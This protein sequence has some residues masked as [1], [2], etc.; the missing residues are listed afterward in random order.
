M[1]KF[2]NITLNTIVIII[3]F[4]QFIILTK[5]SYKYNF[6]YDYGNKLK[7][8]CTKENVEYETNRYQLNN[9]I[10]NIEI[11]NYNHHIILILSIIF[12][13]TISIIFTFIFYN[14]FCNMNKNF[15][16]YS[17]KSKIY[18]LFIILITFCILINP[19]L[20]ILFKLFNLKYYN[21]ISLFNHNINK[22]NLYIISSIFI[23]LI[24]FK[25]IIIY[26]DYNIPEFI[27]EKQNKNTRYI[28]L[29]YFIFYLF[30]YIGTLYYITNIILLY[31]YK[32]KEFTVDKNEF[33]DNKSIIGQYINKLFGLS[34]HDK[35]IE[36]IEYI[37]KVD[38]EIN[39]KPDTKN[40][41]LPKNLNNFN[42]IPIED[43]ENIQK[44]IKYILDNFQEINTANIDTKQIINKCIKDYMIIKY[45]SN[46]P[47]GDKETETNL[48]E[49]IIENDEINSL[50][51]ENKKIIA[52][53][54]TQKISKSIQMLDIKI[55]KNNDI[56]DESEIIEN[57]ELYELYTSD[58]ISIFR[59]NV[60]GLLFIIGI[61]LLSIFIVNFGISFYNQKFCSR[62]KNNIIIPLLSLYILI[63][64]LI[65]NDSFNKIINN[66]IIN[67]PKF[68]YKNNI[69]NIN[70]N[71]NKILENELYIYE[72]TNN[73]LCKNA[74]NSFVSVI[75]NILFHK[76]II[77]NN[78][79]TNII[80]FPIELTIYDNECSNNK[81]DID[82]NLET[83]LDGIFY[84]ITDCSIIY[85]N[86]IKYIIQNTTIYDYNSLELMNLLKDI[87]S[88]PFN[89]SIE[90]TILY[91]IINKNIK[92]ENIKIMITKIKQKLKNLLK[93]TLYN[94]IVLKKSYDNFDITEKNNI[95][96]LSDN[97]YNNYIN[98]E[99][100]NS[101]INKYNYIIDNIIDEYINM[102]LINHYLLSKLVNT[103]SLNEIF[104][105]IDKNEIDY[106]LKK[107]MTEYI[108]NFIELYKTYLNKLNLIFKNKYNL[109][110]K[111]NNISLYLINIYNNINK[112]NPY[113]DDIIYPYSK[114]ENQIDNMSVMVRFNKNL[115]NIINDYDKLR[116]ICNDTI[117]YNNN[118]CNIYNTNY[119]KK[120]LS[121]KIEN[122]VRVNILNIDK[123]FGIIDKIINQTETIIYFDNYF[124]NDKKLIEYNNLTSLLISIKVDNIGIIREVYNDIIINYFNTDNNINK[125]VEKEEFE[126]KLNE[127]NE[128]IFNKFYK[129]KNE[130]SIPIVPS[131]I[132]KKHNERLLDIRDNINYLLKISDS[133]KEKKIYEEKDNIINLNTRINEVNYVFIYLLII[134][135]ILIFLI[136]YI[137]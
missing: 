98:V 74:K 39:E 27:E 113:Y 83:N 57:N 88:T 86:K 15:M 65:S 67:N 19:I 60:E 90:N 18:I 131:A 66:Y 114:T 5:F 96:Y 89:N 56:K 94:T 132:L 43:V 46:N 81:K 10:K 101:E 21:V 127:L 37:K 129:I 75:N 33:S 87:K 84:D 42:N 73:T 77:S 118:E 91:D 64:I 68:I 4:N 102:I 41:N 104:E 72:N 112:E 117:K 8:V 29:F 124:T 76:S 52:S 79:S 125:I 92:H 30:I 13:V 126:N 9:N 36:K 122:I 14:E 24:I 135:A 109:N 97:K 45:D 100:T 7:T 22:T 20:L 54:I 107:D 40:N 108:N 3:I 61:F 59:K 47:L 1:L 6:H 17:F 51:G 53:I 49:L 35:F 103:Y 50:F 32:I 23:I 120:I 31:S 11:N 82:Y 116:I 25:L 130:T 85:Q 134:Y 128:R 123:L 105:K 63:L 80:N 28:E 106:E 78:N 55:K 38:L 121:K 62:I 48:Y 26:Y 133:K 111:T 2:L 71:F 16:D 115:T 137:K 95:N 136:K 70:Y 99:N 119:D 69:N 58:T 110:N 44:Q 12:T 34:E 93:N